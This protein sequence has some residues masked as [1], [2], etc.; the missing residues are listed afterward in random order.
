MPNWSKSFAVRL[1][2]G[3]AGVGIVAAATAALLINA[4]FDERFSSYLD[5]QQRQRERTITLAVEQAYARAGGW[6]NVDLGSAATLTVMDGGTLTVFDDLDEEVWSV[7][8]STSD[9]HSQMHASAAGP[10]GPE[11]RFPVTNGDR[12]VGEV[13]LRLPAGGLLPHD[14]A[15]RATVNRSLTIAGVIAALIAL[16]LGAVLARQATRPARR[17]AEAAR[18]LAA[19]DRGARVEV[20]PPAEFEDLA[21]TFNALADRAEEEDRVRKTLAADVAHELRTPLSILRGQ[22]EAFQDG[23]VPVDDASLASLHEEV[24][25]ISS[26]VADL[27]TI[28]DAEAVSLSMRRERLDLYDET[29]AVIDPLRAGVA[30]RA[31][32]IERSGTPTWVTGDPL[33]LRQVVTNLLA[34]AVAFTSP[35]GTVH[36][37]VRPMSGMGRLEVTDSGAGIPPEELPHVLERFFRGRQARPGGSGIG[38]AVVNE[39][40]R[41]HG[42]TVEIDSAEGEG[43]SVIVTIPQAP[44]VASRSFTGP[45]HAFAN[46]D[47]EGGAR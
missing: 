22:I 37:R 18:A 31:V 17:V 8:P 12:R 33:R 43:T 26:L 38:L 16:I 44:P 28:A 21:R 46:V 13:A 11:R 27:E 42:G 2:A 47:A 15:F 25:R 30:D 19:G 40:V 35:G 23:V 39:I 29:R 3:F 5:Q 20:R 6:E 32:T 9:A 36:V 1:T 4:S 7:T 10:L 24:V 14:V 45:S 34:N 41:A